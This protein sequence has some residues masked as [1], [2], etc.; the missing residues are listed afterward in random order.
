M[1]SRCPV[2][3]FNQTHTTSLS[4]PKQ[5]GLKEGRDVLIPTPLQCWIT[6]KLCLRNGLYGVMLIAD[7]S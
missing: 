7:P 1:R 5:Y 2:Y 6:R 4:G 3:S